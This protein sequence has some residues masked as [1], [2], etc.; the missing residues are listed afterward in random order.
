[1]GLIY[2]FHHAHEQLEA[3]PQIVADMLPYLWGVNLNGMRKEGP[4]I[5]PVGKGNLEQDMISLLLAKGYKGPFGILGHVEDADVEL[6]LRENLSGLSELAK[7]R[8]NS[9]P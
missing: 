8:K 3:Y 1:M 9:V 5:L 4:K 2:N 6:I 7:A